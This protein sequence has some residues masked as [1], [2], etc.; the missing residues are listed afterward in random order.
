MEN[1]TTSADV[2]EQPV[3][4][5][6]EQST[7]DVIT[8]GSAAQVTESVAPS[9]TQTND[10]NDVDENGVPFK[11][12]YFEMQRKYEDITRSIPQMIQEGVTAA[13]KTAVPQQPEYSISDYQAAALK[14][15]D[16]SPYYQQKIMELQQKEIAKTVESK[17]SEYQATQQRKQVEAQAFL[18]SCLT[19]VRLT[20]V[21]QVTLR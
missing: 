20:N 8:E 18:G 21:K 11:N 13:I 19:L 5:S 6:Q 1:E 3:P 17:L 2:I 15:P 12:R 4:A 14:D 16:H 10:V 7:G 9:A